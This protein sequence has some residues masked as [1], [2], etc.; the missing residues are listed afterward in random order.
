MSTVLDWLAG[1]SF[2]DL[3]AIEHEGRVLYPDAIKQRDHKGR[4]VER[5]IMV[6]V[7]RGVERA[8]ARRDARAWLQE[9]GLD[10]AKDHVQFDA[11][12]TYCCVA[13]SLRDPTAPHAQLMPHQELM[14]AVDVRAVLELWERVNYYDRLSEVRVAELDESTFYAAVHAIAKKGN[15]SPLVAIDGATHDVFLTRMASELSSFLTRPA[16]SPSS[17]T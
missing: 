5:K 9:F 4:V 13:R 10:E 12:E 8:K 2:E 11:L 16:S 17:E 6:R 1:K 14:E 3:E 7:P 15:L